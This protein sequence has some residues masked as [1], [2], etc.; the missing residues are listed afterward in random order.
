LKRFNIAIPKTDGGVEL[1]AMKQWLRDHPE[2]MPSGLDATQSTSHQLKGGLRK[3]G[4]STQ[5]TDTEVRLF[6]PGTNA[7]S[8]DLVLGEISDSESNDQGE[9]ETAEAA[10]ALEYQLRDFIAQNIHIISVDGRALRLYVDPTGTDGIEFPTAVGPID[11]LAIDASGHFFVFELK[12][13]RTPDHVVG[14][15]T[16]YMGWVKSTIGKGKDVYGIIVAKQI[17][18]VLRYATTV[19]P[20][21][22]LFEY[23]VEFRL[24]PA[25]ELKSGNRAD[26]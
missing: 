11:I 3:V 2:H 19:I 7:S 14:Q 10:F 9:A 16:R 6:L 5:E 15:L 22:S 26:G 20:K 12:R 24:R 18:D 4:W 8:I 25:N 13:G 21:V 1:Y 17:T 23:E